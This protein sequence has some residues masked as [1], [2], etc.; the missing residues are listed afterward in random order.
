MS[1]LKLNIF[2][3]FLLLS[4]SARTSSLG[5]PNPIEGTNSLPRAR[6]PFPSILCPTL[7]FLFIDDGDHSLPD[8]HS[9]LPSI[10]PARFCSPKVFFVQSLWWQR[11]GGHQKHTHR[12]THNV[13][14]TGTQINNNK[15]SEGNVII[16][17]K[18]EEKGLIII[19]RIRGKGRKGRRGRQEKQGNKVNCCCCNQWKSK[20]EPRSLCPVRLMTPLIGSDAHTRYA[21]SVSSTF[22]FPSSQV[23]IPFCCSSSRYSHRP[24]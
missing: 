14:G 13:A 18:E 11:D 12:D 17:K 20:P 21:R 1:M 24:K 16:I 22:L 3:L 15:P 10:H 9:G 4:C 5:D 2:P 8:T 19:G 6:Q 23:I 7:S